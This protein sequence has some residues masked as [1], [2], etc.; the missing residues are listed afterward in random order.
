MGLGFRGYR[1]F[2]YVGVAS[3]VLRAFGLKASELLLC[4]GA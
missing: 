1:D 3:V 4:Q 2:D